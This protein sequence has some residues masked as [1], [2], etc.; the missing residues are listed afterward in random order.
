MQSVNIKGF[1]AFTF[2]IATDLPRIATKNI[3]PSKEIEDQRME[4]KHLHAIRPCFIV[5]PAFQYHLY[6]YPGKEEVT[7]P[8]S[9]HSVLQ[10]GFST[11]FC[12]PVPIANAW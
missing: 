3:D 8:K 9:Q 6:H 1:G 10:K 7:K 12:N 4:R 2:D 5:D 11:I